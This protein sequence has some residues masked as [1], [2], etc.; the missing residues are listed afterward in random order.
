[1]KSPTDRVIS[2]GCLLT[3]LAFAGAIVW[4]VMY[5]WTHGVWILVTVAAG[6]LLG[7]WSRRRQERAVDAIIHS[8]FTSRSVEPPRVIHEGRYGYAA[9]RLE[10]PSE[11]AEQKAE[12][13]GAMA[14]FLN[15]IQELH[16]GEGPK[17]RPFDAATAVYTTWPGKHG[18]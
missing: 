15:G 9:Y 4:T 17:R 18:A 7:T 6:L 11:A 12:Q 3:F 8:A 2:A 16:Q 14:A 5:G 13:I 1:M 10:F